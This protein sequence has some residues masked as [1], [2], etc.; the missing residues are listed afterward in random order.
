MG[1]KVGIFEHIEAHISQ[2][3]FEIYFVD[4]NVCLFVRISWYTKFL[5]NKYP[6]SVLFELLLWQVFDVFVHHQA[7]YTFSTIYISN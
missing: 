4:K 2:M 7:Y 3:L 5:V 6:D 1:L